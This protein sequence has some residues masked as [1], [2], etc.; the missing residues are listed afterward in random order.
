MKR[1]K[2]P[3]SGRKKGSKN[4]LNR[5]AQLAKALAEAGMTPLEYMLYVMRDPKVRPERRDEMAKA[6][7]PYL[8][9]KRAPENRDG[10][11]IPPMIYTHPPLEAQCLTCGEYH[12][13]ECP[14]RETETKK[15][16]H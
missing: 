13:G 9:A 6:A 14:K 1:K 16:V 3:G 12:P 5:A 11:T 10:H 2:T 7:A 15:M 4:K 8:H